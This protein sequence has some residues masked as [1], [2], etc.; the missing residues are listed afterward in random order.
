MVRKKPI[1]CPNCQN[2]VVEDEKEL[3][4]YLLQKDIIC[5]KCGNV[6]VKAQK[7]EY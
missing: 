7:V 4:H 1:F 2:V 6:V 5:D 3:Q